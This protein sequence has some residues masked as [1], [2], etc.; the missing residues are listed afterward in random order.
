MNGT[1]FAAVPTWMLRDRSIKRTS[2]LV[3]AS[4]ASRSGYGAIFPSQE[5]IAAEAGVS[6]RT[7]RDALRELED[8]GVIERHRRR[9]TEG[10]R[11]TMTTAYVLRPNGPADPEAILAG[12]SEVPAN[13]SEA[14]GERTQITP[15]IEIDRERDNARAKGPHRI[16]DDWAPTA[17]HRAYAKTHFLDVEREAETF[18]AH[19][20]ATGRKLERWDAGFRQ[21]LL[22]ARPATPAAVGGGSLSEKWGAGNEWME[23]R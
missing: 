10:K 4:L 17:E 1:G 16:P 14:T 11:T 3:Y 23:Y 18:R 13:Q 9:S 15:L 21:W 22:K 8:L 2:V 20:E 7:A 12:S 5:T 19:A 6:V